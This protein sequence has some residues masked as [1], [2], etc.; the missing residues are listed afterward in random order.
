M[1]T[2]NVKNL[3]IKPHYPNYIVLFN[4]SKYKIEQTHALFPETF[5]FSFMTKDVNDLEDMTTLRKSDY[6]V[7]PVYIGN[8]NQNDIISVSSQYVFN[9]LDVKF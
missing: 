2:I 8:Y 5:I 1:I 9:A 3:T 4:P 7:Q 6:I